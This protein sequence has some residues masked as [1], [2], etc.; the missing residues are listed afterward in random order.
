MSVPERALRGVKCAVGAAQQWSPA[1]VVLFA[2]T[3]GQ[4]QEEDVDA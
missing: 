1:H 2:G 4:G 3:F